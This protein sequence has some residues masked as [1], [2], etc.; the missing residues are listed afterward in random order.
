VGYQR[1]KVLQQ[2]SGTSS[3]LKDYK[4][5]TASSI[6]PGIDLGA[7]WRVNEMYPAVPLHP[8]VGLVI[9]NIN[10]PKFAQPAQALADGE[11]STYVLN[12]QIRSGLAISPMHFWNIALDLDL[13]KNNT[14]VSGFDSRMFG[15]GTEINV[16]NRSWLNIPLRA[17]LT[18]NTADSASKWAYTAGFGLN[19]LHVVLDVGGAVSTDRVQIKSDTNNTTIPANVSGAVQLGLVF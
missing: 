1:F 3:M 13:T 10:S 14:P 7:L 15:L 9:R 12:R 16:F 17:G 4:S 8:R 19:F 18:K 6:R 11:S 2:N 5:N